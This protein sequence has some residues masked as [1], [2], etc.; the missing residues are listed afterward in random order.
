MVH[1][2]YMGNVVFPPLFLLNKSLES[3]FLCFVYE[4]LRRQGCL[5][6]Y[7]HSQR[8]YVNETTQ[9]FLSGSLTDPDESW[10]RR[11]FVLYLKHIFFNPK[12]KG[13]EDVG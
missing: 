6:R 12:T 9:L 8:S 5:L 13:F 1:K 10:L 4:V 11:F 3:S 2:C 7:T